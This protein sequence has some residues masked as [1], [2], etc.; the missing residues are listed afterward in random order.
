VKKHKLLGIG[1]MF[2][3]QFIEQIKIQQVFF[4]AN[5]RELIYFSILKKLDYSKACCEARRIDL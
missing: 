1:L 4:S 2:Q 5:L 3:K